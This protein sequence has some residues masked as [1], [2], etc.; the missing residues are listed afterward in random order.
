M[1]ALLDAKV[2]EELTDAEYKEMYEENIILSEQMT[3]LNDFLTD[4]HKG[5][6]G[7]FVF[8]VKIDESIN[9][10]SVLQKDEEK[11]V[12]LVV[13]EDKDIRNVVVYF[14]D[15]KM[16]V[17]D[18]LVF[19]NAGTTVK[20]KVS[21]SWW[22]DSC[23]YG[24]PVDYSISAGH[25]SVEDVDLGTSVDRLAAIVFYGIMS[26]ALGVAGAIYTGIY[27]F[28]LETAPDTAGLSYK[29]DLFYHKN[30][31]SAGYIP[32]MDMYVTKYNITWYAEENFDGRTLYETW[33]LCKRMG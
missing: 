28:L 9:E 2:S 30:Q 12:I 21:T 16:V 29:A 8:E 24:R 18:R 19:E 14:K 13:D 5:G 11:T 20:P 15:G 22:A 3:F 4:I 25:R 26:K 1:S 23:P 10:V 32:A 6:D 33:Y 31:R 27:E 7:H 17:D